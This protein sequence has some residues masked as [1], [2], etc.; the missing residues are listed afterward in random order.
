MTMAAR[1]ERQSGPTAARP[2]GASAA[3]APFGRL[4]VAVDGTGA[5]AGAEGVAREWAQRFGAVVR[6]IEPSG[7]RNGDVVRE[8]A[9]A[10]DA[11][12]ADVIVLGF[13]HRRLARHRL[14]HS[15]RERLTR[16]TELPVLVVPVVPG[17]VPAAERGRPR[18]VVLEERKERKEGGAT[19]A[20]RYAGV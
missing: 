15:L 18:V 1:I 7:A 6:R 8:I 14:S 5:A 3:G 12:G 2:D 20:G 11:F 17:V 10:A 13:D 9:R 16:A 4:L 19:D